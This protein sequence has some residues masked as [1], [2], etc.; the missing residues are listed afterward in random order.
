VPAAAVSVILGK[1]AARAAPGGNAEDLQIR[2]VDRDAV[3]QTFRRMIDDLLFQ[4]P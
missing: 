1:K 2:A 4:T 3:V